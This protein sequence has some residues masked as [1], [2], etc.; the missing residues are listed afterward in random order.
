MQELIDFPPPPKL[1]DNLQEMLNA[2]AAKSVSLLAN[3]TNPNPL[4]MYGDG[5]G[6]LHSEDSNRLRPLPSDTSV[7]ANMDQTKWPPEVHEYNEQFTRCLEKIKRRHDPVVTTMAQGVLEYKRATRNL[8]LETDIHRFLDRFYLS[9]IGIRILLGQHIAL[10]RNSESLHDS[11]TAGNMS[12]VGRNGMSDAAT[13]GSEEPYKE[14]FVGIICTNTHVGAI[15]H[16]AIENA[17][18]VCEEHFGLFKG[19]PVQL[20]CP[21]DLTFM[22]IPSHLNVRDKFTS[23]ESNAP[24]TVYSTSSSSYSR[25]HC[26]RLWRDMEWRMRTASPPSRSLSWPETKT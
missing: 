18:F 7:L 8:G 22:Y 11:I 4:F 20:I 13:K 12:L 10:A 16:E 21:K 1:S 23:I 6:H 2:N 9:R 25:T 26:V 3:E 24:L 5:T 14:N 17:R 19:P 15:A